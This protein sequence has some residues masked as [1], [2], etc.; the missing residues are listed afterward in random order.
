MI[1][2]LQLATIELEKNFLR[3]GWHNGSIVNGL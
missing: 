1:L 2:R 3:D